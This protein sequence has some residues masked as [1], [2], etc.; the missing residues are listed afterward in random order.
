MDISIKE[1]PDGITLI[2]LHSGLDN[3]SIKQL[4]AGIDQLLEADRSQIIID[5]TELTYVSSAGIGALVSIHRRVRE[6]RGRVRF[7]GTHGT[8]FEVMELMNL[9]S[10]LDLSPDVDHARRA[11]I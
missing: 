8:V 11:L 7:A 2:A 4:N 1:T 9:G 3:D 5:C 6:A 10:I